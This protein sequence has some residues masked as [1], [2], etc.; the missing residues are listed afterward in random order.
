MEDSMVADA[1]LWAIVT[2]AVAFIWWGCH[3]TRP[4]PKADTEPDHSFENAEFDRAA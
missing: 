3:N 4:T 2:I 1:A